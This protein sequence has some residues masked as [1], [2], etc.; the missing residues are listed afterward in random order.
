[1]ATDGL[2]QVQAVHVG[3][4]PVCDDK[5]EGVGVELFQGILA[6]FGFDQGF[7]TDLA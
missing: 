4:I 2:S 1:M 3:H 6:V 7:V 5:L